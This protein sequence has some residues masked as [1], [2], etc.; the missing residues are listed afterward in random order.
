MA[1]E[2][3]R[4]VANRFCSLGQ[5]ACSNARGALSL[6]RPWA[7]EGDFGADGAL[8]TTIENMNLPRGG[9]ASVESFTDRYAIYARR[10][11]QSAGVTQPSYNRIASVARRVQYA[12]RGLG[13]TAD[14]Y[15][16]LTVGWAM[17]FRGNQVKAL[18]RQQLESRA[19]HPDF[20]EVAAYI[21]KVDP[22]Y[23]TVEDFVTSLAMIIQDVPSWDLDSYA[24]LAAFDA[25]HI[26]KIGFD[27]LMAKPI[28]PSAQREAL[29]ETDIMGL[30]G[31]FDE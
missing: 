29:D 6:N 12:T 11:L 13:A 20:V 21:S 26:P 18:C 3:D 25:H 17:D 19:Q 31:A 27:D 23:D 7:S 1:D 4:F 5:E 10:A 9:P 22:F 24:I 8:Q 14:V 16:Q 30:E 15:E 2:I 28:S